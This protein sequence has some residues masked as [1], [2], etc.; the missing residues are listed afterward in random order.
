MVSFQEYGF[1]AKTDVSLFGNVD[2]RFP[3]WFLP[4]FPALLSLLGR[5]GP[6]AWLPTTFDPCVRINNPTPAVCQKT[7]RRG[8]IHKVLKL[9]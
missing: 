7:P 4:W 9:T 1:C 8:R 6:T 3:A 2:F 5:V